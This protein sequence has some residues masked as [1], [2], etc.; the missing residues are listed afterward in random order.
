MK[1]SKGP[2]GVNLG[3]MSG[4]RSIT[5][6]NGRIADLSCDVEALYRGVHTQV[7]IRQF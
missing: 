1:G 2:F 5:Y 3:P 6:A 4:V 7:A